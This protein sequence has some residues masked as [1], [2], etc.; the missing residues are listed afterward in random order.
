[1]APIVIG[2]VLLALGALLLLCRRWTRWCGSREPYSC[3][4]YG[5]ALVSLAAA[6]LAQAL[7][8]PSLAEQWAWVVFAS[9]LLALGA[10]LWNAA[11]LERGRTE[12]GRDDEGE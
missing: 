2:S 5:L 12:G 8:W 9:L 7:G 3:T 10:G 4:L 1:M 6:A 11:A